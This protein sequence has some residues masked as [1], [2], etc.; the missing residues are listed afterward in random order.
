[1]I[2]QLILENNQNKIDTFIKEINTFE[3]TNYKLIVLSQESL[4]QEIKPRI[5][6]GKWSNSET[7]RLFELLN[8]GSS[9]SNIASLLN[10]SL[11]SVM[12]KIREQIL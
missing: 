2:L 11:L 6:Q 12:K 3:K 10:R 9:V 8:Q 7:K 5:K 1:M 4:R